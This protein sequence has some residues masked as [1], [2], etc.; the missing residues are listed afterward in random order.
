MPRSDPSPFEIADQQ[1]AEIHARSQ[2]GAAQR[3]FV[4]TPVDALH[5]AIELTLVQD[6]VQTVIERVRRRLH[7]IPAGDPE[8]LLPLPLA[9]GPHGHSSLWSQRTFQVKNVLLL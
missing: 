7:H 8:F 1:Q 5:V 6:L 9:A 3:P 4:V 2:T